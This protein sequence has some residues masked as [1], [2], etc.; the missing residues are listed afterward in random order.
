MRHQIDLLTRQCET[1]VSLTT[2]VKKRG[3]KLSQQEINE[4][5]SSNEIMSQLES[6]SIL[7]KI[8]EWK[9]EEGISG[10]FTELP[11]CQIPRPMKLIMEIEDLEDNAQKENNYQLEQRP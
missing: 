7:E 11:P 4:I 1:F 9:K 5:K 8:N 3:K 6:Y 10:T 2:K